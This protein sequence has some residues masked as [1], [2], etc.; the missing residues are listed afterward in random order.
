VVSCGGCFA[1]VDDQYHCVNSVSTLWHLRW[2]WFQLC[3]V[4]MSFTSFDIPIYWNR[5]ST[6]LKWLLKQNQLCDLGSYMCFT[7][8]WR[9]WV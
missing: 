7:V 5:I 4:D 8:C 2:L 3:F 9:L 6:S 1:P